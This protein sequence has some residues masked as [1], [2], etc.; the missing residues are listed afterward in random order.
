MKRNLLYLSIFVLLNMLLAACSP[1]SSSPGPEVVAEAT[2]ASR[3]EPT[4]ESG[5]IAPMDGDIGA[6]ALI[7]Q[8]EAEQVLGASTGAGEPE[9]TPPIYSCSYETDNFDLVQVVVVVYEDNAQALDA[10]QMAIDI[11]GYPELSGLGDRAY[12]AQPIFDVNVLIGNMEISIDISDSS[13]DAAQLQKA[14][15]LAQV[16]LTRLP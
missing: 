12:N 8:S 13:D 7:T 10:Y 4:Q 3:P 5:V 1:A 11:N 14:I 15:D 6:C 16:A 9:D 2:D